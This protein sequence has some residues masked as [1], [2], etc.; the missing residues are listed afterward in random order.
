MGTTH[1]PAFLEVVH[2]PIKD[3]AREPVLDR[4]TDVHLARADE[5][6]DDAEAIERAE[7]AREEAVRDALAV[8]V[9]VQHDHALLDRHR[10]R[11]LARRAAAAAAAGER[12]VLGE[13]RG[14]GAGEG[15]G[16]RGAG[17]G[18]AGE[19]VG[20]GVE[21]EVRVRVDDGA[22]ALWIL[23]VLDANRDLAPNNLQRAS[24]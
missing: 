11:E 22:A 8:R 3:L 9:Y 1:R 17:A 5:V 12:A 23:D 24:A 19:E 15:W 18:G 13:E 7:D 14:E 2:Q 10:R 4:H 21:I 6:D 20:D 16:G